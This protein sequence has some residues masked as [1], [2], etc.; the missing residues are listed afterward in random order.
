[1]NARSIQLGAYTSMLFILL[2]G[3][4]PEHIEPAVC[5]PG[6]VLVILDNIQPETGELAP[7]KL[8]AFWRINGS[9]RTSAPKK[10]GDV[11][12]LGFCIPPELADKESSD[13]RITVAGRDDN[14]TTY[15][16]AELNFTLRKIDV[17]NQVVRSQVVLR[18]PR[19]CG[20]EGWC[21][22]NPLPQG[23]D[24]TSVYSRDTESAW[25][26]GDV[27]LILHWNGAYWQKLET[28]TE[29]RLVAL[30]VDEK[31]NAWIG[32]DR[33]YLFHC[34]N[35]ECVQVPY[36]QTTTL[37]MGVEAIRGL[38]SAHVYAGGVGL[39]RCSDD[40]CDRIYDTG[41][42]VIHA[43]ATS[44]N[45]AIY[46]VGDKGRLVHCVED[47]CTP[48]ITDSKNTLRAVA[49]GKDGKI[50][51]AGDNGE[52]LQCTDEGC[53]KMP[54]NPSVSIR[55]MGIMTNGDAVLGGAPFSVSICNQI[56]CKSVDTKPAGKTALLNDLHVA[57]DD[58]IWVAAQDQ[59]RM[60]GMDEGAVLRC[61][62]ARCGRVQVTSERASQRKI[63]GSDPHNIWSVGDAG[64]IV[65]C[66]SDDGCSVRS[67]GPTTTATAGIT[68]S[69]NL[70]W[71][72]T[73]V[74]TAFYCE[75]GQGC[76]VIPTTYEGA[77]IAIGGVSTD[78][79][80]ISAWGGNLSTCTKYGCKAIDTGVGYILRPI[81]PA[82]PD[83]VWVGGGSALLFRCG[84]T[85]CTTVQ[86]TRSGIN[87]SGILSFDMN[88]LIAVGDAASFTGKYSQG[89]LWRC[90]PAGCKR[91]VIIEGKEV[92]PLVVVAG[93]DLNNVWIMGSDGPGDKFI[94]RC[95]QTS[96]R[97]VIHNAD[98]GSLLT[99]IWVI[100]D[101]LAY[102]TGW[103][104][105]YL[106]CSGTTCTK[107]TP[108]AF[109]LTA[110]GALTNTHYFI[111]GP[112]GYLRECHR[113]GDVDQCTDL[114]RLTRRALGAV[115]VPDQNTAW[116]AGDA[117]T[118]L[119]YY[120][121]LRAR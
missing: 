25:G 97:E 35:L 76:T 20:K 53:T 106:R 47:V 77:Q 59:E 70:V 112:Y 52:Y 32:G 4:K 41:S 95:N 62:S 75:A 56:E 113:V 80:W 111:T 86:P 105:L 69:S 43:I 109:D 61:T 67:S 84:T 13:L 29:A 37:G 16:G 98:S 49:I 104:G 121:E 31:D 44:D 30:W 117:G 10:T 2:I 90:N 14:D 40:G 108:G 68:G 38:D 71:G 50:H 7:S 89:A 23:A 58:S 15:L 100:N 66:S 21:W 91:D 92:P 83:S 81:I 82:G 55:N 11:K 74:G 1:M 8:A 24:L 73:E 51:T 120:P 3:C 93:L 26:I 60:S 72:A 101:D 116:I 36:T 115:L 114:K 78:R 118:L 17:N 87:I 64:S 42:D 94:G 28:T 5:E 103:R 119:R 39:F 19:I 57:S 12:Q 46:A 102:I 63:S 9:V 34:T 110:I 22:E 65:Q 85:K 27:G 99:G 96:C 88:N 45:R 6:D 54:Q 33:G 107:M 48:I 79:V 18:R